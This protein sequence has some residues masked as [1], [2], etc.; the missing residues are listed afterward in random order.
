MDSPTEESDEGSTPSAN[1]TI[2]SCVPPPL[3]T[4]FLPKGIDD[5]SV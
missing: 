5:S 4:V 2:L 1:S 3:R